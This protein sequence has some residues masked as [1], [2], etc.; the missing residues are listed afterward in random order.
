M[1]LGLVL[2]TLLGAKVD[3][4]L[5]LDLGVP[6]DVV[7]VLLRIDGGDLAAD[8]LQ[9]L[10]DPNGRVSMTCVVGGRKAGR[11]GAEDR[12]VDDVAHARMLARRLLQMQSPRAKL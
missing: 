11:A 3:E 6:G 2:E 5:T 12:D 10:D 4:C 7:D 1:H 9:A 8:L